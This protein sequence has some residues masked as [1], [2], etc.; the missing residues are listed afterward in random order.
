MVVDGGVAGRVRSASSGDEIAAFTATLEPMAA[1]RPVAQNLDRGPDAD[2]GG[3]RETM[4]EEIAL[5]SR[6]PAVLVSRICE[7][8][9]P[10]DLTAVADFRREVKM[11][12]H[13]A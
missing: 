12:Q 11:H 8:A 6:L 7:M 9:Q 3:M 1:P 5:A 2:R 4:R 13:S 10:I